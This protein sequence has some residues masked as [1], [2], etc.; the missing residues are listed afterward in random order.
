MPAKRKSLPRKAKS[1]LR[2]LTPLLQK[3]TDLLLKEIA[4]N[5]SILE[6]HLT[7][8]IAFLHAQGNV[9]A[10]NSGNKPTDQEASFATVAEKHG[11]MFLSKTAPAPENGCYYLY[12]LKGTQQDGD[13]CLREYV[14]GEVASELIID[15]KHTQSKAFYLNDGWFQKGVVYIVSWNKG[16]KKKPDLKA[17]IAFGED[18]PSEEEQTLMAA[19]NAFKLT[20]NTGE[21][22]IGSL[23]PYVRFA[24]KYTCERF[25]DETSKVH[26]EKVLVALE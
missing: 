18:I 16:T 10:Q 2:K 7:E 25:T 21:K 14:E 19:L 5:P 17:Y 8:K 9:G 15:L 13:F 6:R 23:I 22:K 4:S 11:F 20:K 1:V 12:Q 24:N 3:T 26:L